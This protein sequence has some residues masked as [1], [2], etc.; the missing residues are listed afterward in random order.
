MT[1][2]PSD[3]DII[4][5]SLL[6]KI[7]PLQKL[8]K[9]KVFRARVA[10]G[11]FDL[12]RQLSRH[13]QKLYQDLWDDRKLC[14]GRKGVRV[15]THVAMFQLGKRK[16]KRRG[17]AREEERLSPPLSCSPLNDCET[18]LKRK[19]VDFAWPLAISN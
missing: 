9:E 2:S 15:G 19:N 12:S 14:C 16:G 17:G 11:I 3:A 18:Y 4:T 13:V 6:T 5:G 10:D 1:P 8:H 7:F